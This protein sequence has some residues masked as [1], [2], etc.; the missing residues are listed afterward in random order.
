[1]RERAAYLLGII[2]LPLTCWGIV[3]TGFQNPNSVIIDPETGYIY[4]SNVNGLLTQK[5]DNGFIS[6]ISPDGKMITLRFID[7]SLNE[8]DLHAPKGMVIKKGALYVADID[9]I[10]GFDLKERIN[11]HNIN[12]R[13]YG[14]RFLNDIAL[15]KEGKLIITDSLA[16]IL[17]EVEAKK[18]AEVRVMVHSPLLESPQGICVTPQGKILVASSVGSTIWEINGRRFRRL[19]EKRVYYRFI[20]DVDY[21]TKG[22]I[23]FADFSGGRIFRLSPQGKVSTFPGYFRSPSGI[24]IDREK[25]RIIIVESALNRIQIL[26]LY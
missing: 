21:D 16:N 23:Y 5:D 6:R 14:A 1:M 9:T 24:A 18:G 13:P 10:R 25:N 3:I 26:P 15:D 11:I 22:N 17:F 20:K 2:L 19:L 4:V 12:L 8:Y 7:G